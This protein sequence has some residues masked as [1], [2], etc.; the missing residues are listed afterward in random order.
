MGLDEK[1]IV[2]RFNKI[3]NKIDNIHSKYDNKIE[4]LEEKMSTIDKN[5][6]VNR[7]QQDQQYKTIIGLLD[8][9]SKTID[10][11]NRSLDQLQSSLHK[12]EVEYSVNDYKTNKTDDFI[13][14]ITMQLIFKIL[15]LIF[16]AS[17]IIATFFK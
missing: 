8:G 1:D 16:G 10:V 3:D 17:A 13:S 11:L 9:Q 4:R 14:K 7:A 6:D 15:G 12:M 5:N 2:D